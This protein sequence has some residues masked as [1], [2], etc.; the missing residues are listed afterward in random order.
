MPSCSTN[1][2]HVGRGSI[3]CRFPRSPQSAV[4][5]DLRPAYLFRSACQRSIRQIMFLAGCVDLC[6]RPG[7]CLLFHQGCA[8]Y[9]KTN[10]AGSCSVT[11]LL[12]PGQYRLTAYCWSHWPGDDKETDAAFEILSAIWYTDVDYRWRLFRVLID[13]VFLHGAWN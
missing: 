12:F 2:I 10:A 7:F 5:A 13:T 3:F 6:L 8:G 1:A 9:S 4:C 11:F